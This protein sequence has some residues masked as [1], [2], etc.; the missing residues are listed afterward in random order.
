[1][2]KGAKI[3]SGETTLY[4]AEER[5]KLA[6][7]SAW[8]A[9]SVIAVG[10]AL[11]AAN[12]FHIELINILWPGF[13]LAPGL[14]LLWP[15][16]SSTAHRNHPLSFL[17]VPGAFIVMTS[18]LLFM[19]NLPDH[20]EAWAY[21]WTLAFAAAAAGLTYIDRFEPAHHIHEKA[22]KF[23]RRM[24]YLFIG[25]AVFFELVVFGNLTPWLPIALI[26]YGLYMLVKNNRT[27]AIA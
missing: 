17:A 9:Y 18:L 22:H 6:L 21:S 10:V 3:M 7:P 1:M 14:L 23:I 16:H 11:L 5:N 24:S 2:P 13:V 4:K 20:F 27:K 15:A 25:F 12:I 19:M 26:G 8:P